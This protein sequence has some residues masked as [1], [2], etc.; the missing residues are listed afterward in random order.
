MTTATGTPLPPD[1][2]RPLPTNHQPLPDGRQLVL[3]SPSARE[4]AVTM[5][6]SAGQAVRT[7]RITSDT[8]VG[9][10]SND[11]P[12][13][14][15][16]DPVVTL[17][18]YDP[19][20]GPSET[21]ALRLT[22]SGAQPR[23]HL[24]SA[25]WGDPPTTEFQAGPGQSYYQLQ[26]SRTTGVKIVRYSLSMVAP[27]PTPT[28]GAVVPAPTPSQAQPA[29]TVAPTSTEQQ[30]AAEPASGS[31]WLWAGGIALAILAAV[32][33][34]LLIWR[35][36]H[37]PPT[38]PPPETTAPDDTLDLTQPPTTGDTEEAPISHEPETTTR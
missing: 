36:R 34:A 26:T 5:V 22:A 3:T 8:D 11:R 12:A 31:W 18:V 32:A 7:W 2:Q 23:L 27:A 20:F 19:R 21:L 6:D 10:Q 14:V 33:G 37:R 35:R 30:P 16:G 25:I 29:P 9:L 15:G 4:L 13:L 1:Q 38:A 17:F 28:G 24:K